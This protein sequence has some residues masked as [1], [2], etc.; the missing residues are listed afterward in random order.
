MKPTNEIPGVPG[1]HPSSHSGS[2]L[3]VANPPVSQ[4]GGPVHAGGIG[5]LRLDGGRLP[6]SVEDDTVALPSMSVSQQPHMDARMARPGGPQGNLQAYV[7]NILLIFACQGA[8]GPNNSYHSF[9][10]KS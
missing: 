8:T 9:L 10:Q 5:E 3:H 7:I 1:S 4:S 6:T 2:P